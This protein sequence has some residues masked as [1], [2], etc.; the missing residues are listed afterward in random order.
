[1]LWSSTAT[2]ASGRCTVR[3]ASRKP[4]KACVEVIS[5]TRCR[6]IYRI[7]DSPGAS[8][9]T[10]A[11]QIFSNIVFG[12]ACFCSIWVSFH[13]NMKLFI[14]ILCFH[15]LTFLEC[16]RSQADQVLVNMIV[17]AYTTRDRGQSLCDIVEQLNFVEDILVLV[18]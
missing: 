12:T 14:E 10:W 15:Y 5:C 17:V 2:V 11:S 16:P 7:V 8:R 13:G 1:M 4:A 18:R 6:S 9:T 3:S